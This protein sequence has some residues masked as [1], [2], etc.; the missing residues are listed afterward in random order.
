MAQNCPIKLT[1]SR[2]KYCKKIT[3]SVNVSNQRKYANI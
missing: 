1:A 3:Q 2:D